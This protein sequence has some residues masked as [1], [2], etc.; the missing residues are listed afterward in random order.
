MIGG[1]EMN[2][3]QIE[4]DVATGEGMREPKTDRRTNTKF[5]DGYATIEEIV[6]DSDDT[7]ELVEYF[8][9]DNERELYIS[10]I[11]RYQDLL[12][13]DQKYAFKSRINN[14]I[15]D[16]RASITEIKRQYRL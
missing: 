10:W 8:Q 1:I 7:N 11:Q 12:N 5:R 2:Y 3:E 15:W 6:S 13:S 16:A 9:R 4:Y 14:L